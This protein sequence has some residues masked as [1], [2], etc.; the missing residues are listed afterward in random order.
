MRRLQRDEDSWHAAAGCSPW[1][2]KCGDTG[3]D[4]SGYRRG[5][6]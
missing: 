1:L 2:N 4:A 6:I 5:L 3:V